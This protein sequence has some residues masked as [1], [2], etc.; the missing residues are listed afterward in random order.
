MNVLSLLKIKK[1]FDIN[2]YPAT[3][4]SIQAYE[5]E[6]MTE[7]PACRDWGLARF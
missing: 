2:K 6:D 4:D 7:R 1:D 5:E 3:I